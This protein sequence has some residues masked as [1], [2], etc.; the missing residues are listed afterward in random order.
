MATD[1]AFPPGAKLFSLRPDFA[2]ELCAFDA[3]RAPLPKADVD[4]FYAKL[5]VTRIGALMVQL[6]NERRRHFIPGRW[7][8]Y[9]SMVPK[10]TT[11]VVPVVCDG[12]QAVS[13]AW[14]ESGLLEGLAK[15]AADSL[16]VAPWNF[17][18][19]FMDSPASAP[20]STLVSRSA[21]LHDT[22]K[23]VAAVLERLLAIKFAR[24]FHDW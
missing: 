16:G 4:E 17:T 2:D 12:P 6:L 9:Y 22:E 8:V 20:A 5:G 3:A 21:V 7:V 1:I 13:L 10:Q 19:V 11:R 18:D 23:G 15:K 24:A 14:D